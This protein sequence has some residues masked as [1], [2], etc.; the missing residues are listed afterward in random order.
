ML[1]GRSLGSEGSRGFCS[2]ETWLQLWASLCLS[3]LEALQHGSLKAQWH[4]KTKCLGL[5]LLPIQSSDAHKDCVILR[6]R[7]CPQKLW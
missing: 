3:P 7:D 5:I 6:A 4:L 1:L 2:V